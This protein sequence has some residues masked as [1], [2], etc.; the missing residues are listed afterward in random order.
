MT[1]SKPVPVHNHQLDD[2]SLSMIP[3]CF[4]ETDQVG[5]FAHNPPERER[6]LRLLQDLVAQ[7][8]TWAVAEQAIHQWLDEQVAANLCSASAVAPL[9]ARVQ[10]MFEPW[11]AYPSQEGA[12]SSATAAQT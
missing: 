2:I 9:M 12:R 8:T 6:A 10:A 5:G 4:G 3:G 1:V 11:L 7:R